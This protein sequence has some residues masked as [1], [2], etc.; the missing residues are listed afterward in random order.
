MTGKNNRFG[1]SMR[2]VLAVALC[3]VAA[4]GMYL[5]ADAKGGAATHGMTRAERIRAKLESSDRDYV[6]VVMH[7]G[8]WRHAPEN[9]VGAI[10]GAINHGA[11]IVEID[12][13]KT[14]DGR[15]VL[16][17][18]DVIDRVTNGKG[19]CADYTLEELKKFRLRS[20]DGKTLT[21]YRILSLEEAFNITRGKILVNLDK[22]PRD[23]KG[24]AEC[25]RRCGMER[26]VVLKGGFSPNALK[27][28]MGEQWGGIADGTFLYMPILNI[29]RPNAV[30]G[31]NAWQKA[32]RIPFGYELCFKTE[33]PLDVLERLERVQDKNGPRIWINT[34]WDSLCAGHTDK[35]GFNGD[36][37]GSW[38]W[39]LD[40]KATIIQT[41]RPKELITY[42]RKKGRRNLR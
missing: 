17:H 23:P 4:L 39:C 26:E 35:R 20:S 25:V 3:A 28:R 11:D 13:A 16:L 27:E 36:P 38:G 10:K 7:R 34:L 15:Y 24:I 33:E 32:E 1:N 14:K 42:L 9:S 40:R 37:D 8:D 19:A 5:H 41:D 2:S 18:D 29:N 6:F 30:K 12:V 22:F 31:F 21:N